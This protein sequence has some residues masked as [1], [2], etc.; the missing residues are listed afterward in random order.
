MKHICFKVSYSKKIGTGHLI[1]C[2]ALAKN[3]KKKNIISYLILNG[4]YF[5]KRDTKVYKNYFKK[6]IFTK[7]L[8][9]EINFLK[10]H[11]ITTLVVDN[12]NFGFVS[13]KKI[14]NLPQ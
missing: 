6:I 2:C 7:H 11:K 4:E 1:R 14:K 10:K 9:N 12:P 13:Q 5:N 8:I 3:L